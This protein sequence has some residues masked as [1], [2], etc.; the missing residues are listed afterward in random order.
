VVEKER[1]VTFDV[2]AGHSLGEWSALVAVGALA[3]ADAVR[4]VNLRGTAMQEAVAPGVGAMAALLGLED[5][6]VREVCDEASAGQV[7]QPA[8][9]NGGG[10]V[11]ISG[12]AAAV[13]RAMKLA[14]ARGAKRAVPLQVSAPFH[15]ALM[16]P[17]AD[18]MKDA[19]GE[20]AFGAFAR[21]VVSNVTAEPFADGATAR[22]LLVKQ[23]TGSVLWDQ[24][25][26]RKRRDGAV[27]GL[28]LGHGAVL[29]GLVRRIEPELKVVSVG[30]P[31]D[32]K[33]VENE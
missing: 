2:A 27:R 18:R 19:L 11:V 31:D 30:S 10:Q 33:N 28:E 15:C 12:H 20:T 22:D 29:R 3:L 26:I 13:E 17:A 7:C 25:V 5:A 6:L 21:P 24:S 8:N 1:A 14:V 32:L 23:V 16:Q 4:L 9:F